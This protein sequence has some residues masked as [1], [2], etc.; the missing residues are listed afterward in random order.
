MDF[1]LVV[2]FTIVVVL[3][4]EA[5]PS[6]LRQSGTTAPRT[7]HRVRRLIAEAARDDN[8]LDVARF[9][10]FDLASRNSVHRRLE[11]T[12]SGARSGS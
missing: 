9:A 12:R 10:R 11:P 3:M 8:P 6:A 7:L 1:E 4:T 2:F 5:I